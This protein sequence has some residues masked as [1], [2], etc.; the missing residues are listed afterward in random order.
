MG[1]PGEAGAGSAT[2]NCRKWEISH[3]G[4]GV[5]HSILAFVASRCCFLLLLLV[6]VLLGMA[7]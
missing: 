1:S 4:S 7:L 5:W 2:E 6:V 3:N